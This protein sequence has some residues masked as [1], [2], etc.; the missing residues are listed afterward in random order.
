[1]VAASGLVVV[2][3]AMTGL[4]AVSVRLEDASIV[5]PF[6][7]PGFAIV[8]LTYLAAEGSY[9]ARGLLALGLVSVW[10]ARLG[11]HL[12]LRNRE[13]G[14]DKRYR[15]MREA[16]GARFWWVSLFT[17]FWLQ[18]I[19]LWIISAPLYGAVVD[20][21]PL[22]RGTRAGCYSS[23]S[24]SRSKPSRTPSW[25]GSRRILRTGGACSTPGSGAIADTPTTSER[26][27]CGGACT[28]SPSARE[29]T[30]P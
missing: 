28:S 18:A 27:W 15:Q 11:L 20:K 19:L 30:G 25:S 7:G 10:A 6:W 8:T 2:L 4:W 12:L 21:A 13:E 26:L 23:W 24:G 3:A 29:R 5:D 17:V 16:R 9:N 1:M 14:E 22:G